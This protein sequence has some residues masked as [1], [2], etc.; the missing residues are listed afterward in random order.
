MIICQKKKKW[1]CFGFWIDDIKYN[2]ELHKIVLHKLGIQYAGAELFEESEWKNE[3]M[4]GC[5][6]YRLNIICEL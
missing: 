1:D 3:V 5:G 6:V 4:Y 2:L